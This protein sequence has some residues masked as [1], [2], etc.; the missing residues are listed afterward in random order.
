LAVNN[1]LKIPNQDD[2]LSRGQFE[3]EKIGQFGK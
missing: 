1:L 2:F 3:T